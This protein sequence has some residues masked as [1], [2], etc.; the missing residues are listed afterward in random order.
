MPQ[1]LALRAN[2]DGT[3]Y[4]ALG[5]DLTLQA[6]GRGGDAARNRGYVSR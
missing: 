1:E 3:N 6:G 5:R 2:S 4:V